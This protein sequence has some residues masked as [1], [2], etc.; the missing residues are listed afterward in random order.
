MLADFQAQA[1][2][3]FEE[4]ETEPGFFPQVQGSHTSQEHLTQIKTC[5]TPALYTKIFWAA[6]SRQLE[7]KGE[8]P[9]TLSDMAPK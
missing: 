4:E 7:I 8:Q 5:V 3:N 9:C 6:S 2:V 1:E